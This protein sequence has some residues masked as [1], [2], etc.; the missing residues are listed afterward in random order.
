M[1]G[2]SMRIEGHEIGKIRIIFS[3]SLVYNMEILMKTECEAMYHVCLPR[4]YVGE[5]LLW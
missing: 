1:G 5:L 4:L 2:G 3:S